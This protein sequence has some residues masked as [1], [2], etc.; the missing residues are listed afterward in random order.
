MCTGIQDGTH[1]AGLLIHFA[2]QPS[3]HAIE[4]VDVGMP[5][6]NFDFNS[7]SAQTLM[8]IRSSFRAEFQGTGGEG[9]AVEMG[10]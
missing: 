7:I 2:N 9:F 6:G 3:G 5:N 8:E 4:F 1:V 10:S